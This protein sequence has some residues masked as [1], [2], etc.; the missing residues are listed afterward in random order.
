M[1]PPKHTWYLYP[2]VIQQPTGRWPQ[3]WAKRA[4]HHLPD[5]HPTQFPQAAQRCLQ[6]WARELCSNHHLSTMP[7]SHKQLEGTQYHGQGDLCNSHCSCTLSSSNRQQEVH[8][9]ASGVLDEIKSFFSYSF[10]VFLDPWMTAL[11]HNGTFLWSATTGR[12]LST[13][14][15]TD[16]TALPLYAIPDLQGAPQNMGKGGSTKFSPSLIPSKYFQILLFT[17]NRG[18]R[19]QCSAVP[20]AQA[21]LIPTLILS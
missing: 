14:Q 3:P 21:G 17:L 2:V 11:P 1:G 19:S 9:R 20:H 7:W 6:D 10:Q 16:K 18:I 12:E 15:G 4:P 13:L 5:L 8:T